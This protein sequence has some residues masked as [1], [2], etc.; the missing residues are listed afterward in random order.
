KPLV[1][2]VYEQARQAKRLDDIVVA[3]DDTRILEVV[4]GFGGNAVLTDPACPSGT[5]R[6][7]EVARQYPCE[8][9]VN[10]QGDE[11]LMKPGMIDQLVAGMEAEPAFPVGTL[12]RPVESVEVW[13]NSNV[14]K[15]V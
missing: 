14:V 2:R 12:A 1:Q 13:A 10:I 11:P 8:L 6:A 3:T 7:A 15:V 5:D 9:I 4:E